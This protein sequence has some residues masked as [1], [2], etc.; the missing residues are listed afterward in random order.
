MCMF[1]TAKAAESTMPPEYASAK[2]PTEKDA[3][4]AGKR[5]KNRLRAKAQ[6]LL[7]GSNGTGAV[8]STGGKALL[9]Q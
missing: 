9:G 7:A 4:G 6:T 3:A 2:S 1:S 5:A 8:D